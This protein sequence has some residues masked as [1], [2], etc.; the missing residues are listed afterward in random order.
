MQ[1]APTVPSTLNL[2]TVILAHLLAR[3]PCVLWGDPGIGKTSF[4]SQIAKAINYNFYDMTL[5]IYL[6]EDIAGYTRPDDQRKVVEKYPLDVFATLPPKTL[7]LLDEFGSVNEDMQGACMQLLLTRRAGAF[8][9]PNEMLLMAAGN[10]FDTAV[11]AHEIGAPLANR[12]AHI[13]FSLPTI[14]EMEDWAASSDY[15]A[16]IPPVNID[17]FK[18]TLPSLFR[19]LIISFLHG[20]PEL[21]LDVPKTRVQ[22]ARAWPS[23]RSWMAT[24]DVWQ[25]LC[26]ICG[27]D[28]MA[29]HEGSALLAY[30]AAVCNVGTGPATELLA[31]LKTRDL[32]NIRELL[33]GTITWSPTR[34]DQAYVVC[35][36]LVSILLSEPTRSVFDRVWDLFLSW[37]SEQNKPIIFAA[38][39]AMMRHPKLKT[40]RMPPNAIKLLDL[41]L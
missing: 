32:P 21:R 3:K 33:E 17:D 15:V 22:R 41:A 30:H 2:S 23:P 1:I 19:L 24:A 26:Y 35:S 6:P 34:R 20:R 14:E 13:E 29:F 16:K 36:S 7:L 5:S 31:W 40:F 25:A 37:Y 12:V 8:V 4:C 38:A 39:V 9:L 28:P 10:N 27:K 11:N 18:I